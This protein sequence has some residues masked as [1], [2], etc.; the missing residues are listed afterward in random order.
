M[1]Q[2]ADVDLAQRA[3][4]ADPVACESLFADTIDRVYAFVLRRTPSA[5]VAQHVTERALIRVFGNLARY[6]GSVPLSAWVLSIV[7]Q[8]L[9]SEALLSRPSARPHDSAAPP[10]SGG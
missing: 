3:A 10:G 6:E 9:R 7:K 2:R 5:E 8:E 1:T 4:A